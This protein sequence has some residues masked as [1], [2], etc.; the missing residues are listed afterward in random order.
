MR[1]SEAPTRQM[2]NWSIVGPWH[3]DPQKSARPIWSAGSAISSILLM[4]S[5][6]VS[7]NRREVCKTFIAGS[8][9]AVASARSTTGDRPYGQ[10]TAKLGERSRRQRANA[11]RRER[12]RAG[13]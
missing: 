9:P 6:S 8:I 1:S 7:K 10:V 12:L 4:F 11:A 13:S 5:V 3:R 2:L